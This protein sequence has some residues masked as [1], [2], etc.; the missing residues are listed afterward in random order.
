MGKT[1]VIFSV[2]GDCKQGWREFAQLTA[3]QGLM[4]LTFLWRDCGPAGPT[5]EAALIQN[6]VN[7]AR[8]AINFVRAQG[9]EKIILAGA[10]LGGVAS[11]KLAVESQASGIIVL[12][13]P[14]Q[15]PGSDF[16]VEAAE[17]NTDIPKL[18]LSAEEDYVVPLEDSRAL[19]DLAAE[20]REWQTYPSNEHGTELFSTEMGG[21]IQLRILE[22]ILG[23]ASTN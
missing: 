8:G 1:A 21:E 19:Y 3:A 23:I 2:M 14:L 6:F 5:N 11:A 10:S 9:A 18:F 17:L 22:F 4:A 15:I 16:K 13:A 7:D 12:A 20:P